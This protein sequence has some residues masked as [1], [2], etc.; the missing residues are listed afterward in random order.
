MSRFITRLAATALASGALV[1]AAALPATAAGHDDHH[2]HQQRSSVVLGAIQHDSPG[3]D[4]RSNRSLNAEWVTV[5]NTGRHAVNLSGW[6]LTDADHHTYRFH[7]VRLAGRESVR[8]HTGTGRD[9][10]HDLYQD[11]R[12]YIWNKDT[13]T[14]T[15][16]DDRGH[17]ID[18]TSRGHQGSGHRH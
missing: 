18:V 14:A 9:T 17:T 3:R 12:A 1:A 5:T 7:H 6:T 13:A 10:H 15:L 11:R 2:R 8:V 4:N 16:R